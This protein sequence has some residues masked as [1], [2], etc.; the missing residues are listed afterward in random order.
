MKLK[1]FE[2]LT[3]Q[4]ALQA[5]KAEL[6]LDAVIVSTRRITKNGGLLG[7]LTQRMVEVTAAVDPPK[8]V[9]P[10]SRPPI[11]EMVTREVDAQERLERIQSWYEPPKAEVVEPVSPTFDAHFQAATLLDPLTQQITALREDVKGVQEERA[12]T[13]A[14]ISPLRQEIEQVRTMMEGLVSDR[15]GK[16]AASFPAPLQVYYQAL[17]HKGMSPEFSYGL[18]RSV[19]ET[20]GESGLAQDDMVEEVLKEKMAQSLTVAG[21]LTAPGDVPKI[22]ML[23][24]PTG[25]GKTTTVA[26]L[27][28]HFSQGTPKVKTVVITVDTYRVAAVEQLR[29]YARILKVPLEVAVTPDELPSCVARHLDAGLILIDTAGRSP[30]DSAG[31]QDLLSLSRKEMT[32]ETHLVLSAPTAPSVL[33]E[34]VRHYAGVPIHRLLFTKLDENPN[35]GPLVNLA[36]QTG[37]PVSYLTTGQRVPEDI[38]E[39]RAAAMVE[40][41]GLGKAVGEIRDGVNRMAMDAA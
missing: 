8:I 40:R 22:V 14:M 3:L 13:R 39:A 29:V 4:E 30:L 2:A 36:H 34:M 28:S 21:P 10:P 41:A 38:E 33:Q 27:A 23:V 26:K 19:S 1:R 7:L 32:L 35:V 11:P 16:R 9:E 12:D 37:L 18:L 5:V 20:L 17:L 25:V 6:G 15:V 24:G 31:Q